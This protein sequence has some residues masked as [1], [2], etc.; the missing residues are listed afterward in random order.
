MSDFADENRGRVPA[1]EWVYR[2]RPNPG[3]GIRLIC[4]PYAGGSAQIYRQWGDALDP[5]A[6]VLAV[7]LPARGNRL[8]EK[9]LPRMDSLVGELSS[10]LDAW[11]AGPFALLG[12]SLGALL[13]YELS[14]DLQARGKSPLALF[15]LAKTPPQLPP[16]GFSVHLLD[17]DALVAEMKSRYRGGPN[18][19]LL[20][21]PELR[22]VFLPA[23]RADM[24]LLETYRFVKG[25]PLSF[26]VYAAGAENDDAAPP[27]LMEGWGALT[28][29]RFELWRFAG[30]HFFWQADF[31]PLLGK[32]RACLSEINKSEK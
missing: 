7:Q 19:E 9:P 31:E 10:A 17:D 18:M 11:I 23:I 13:A 5:L 15:V 6:E 8:G 14:R 24:A 32:L 1:S 28:S 4:F 25:P 30:G 21:D 20:D 29:A 12:H 3:A 22:S 2:P 26:P 16:A 27:P